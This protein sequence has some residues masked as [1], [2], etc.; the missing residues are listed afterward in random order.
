MLVS[1]VALLMA[2]AVAFAQNDWPYA[3]GDSRG[4]RYSNLAEIDRKNV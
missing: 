4:M 1:L 2:A 3:G